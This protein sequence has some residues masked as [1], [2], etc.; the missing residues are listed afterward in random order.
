MAVALFS[1]LPVERETKDIFVIYNN[2]QHAKIAY[3]II[4]K[5]VFNKYYKSSIKAINNLYHCVVYS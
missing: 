1:I 4:C 2:S 5:K 3:L